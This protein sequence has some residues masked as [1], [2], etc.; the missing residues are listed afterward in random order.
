MSPVRPTSGVI[1][2]PEKVRNPHWWA[3]A[4]PPS[5][6]ATKLV[7]TAV[8]HGGSSPPT[9][10]AIVT[11]AS[12]LETRCVYVPAGAEQPA[13]STAVTVYVV[14]AAGATVIVRVVAPVDQRYDEYPAPAS[15]VIGA[16]AQLGSLPA[17]LVTTGAAAAQMASVAVEMLAETAPETRR[18]KT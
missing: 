16:P 4:P 3:T 6:R 2:P 10:V 12:E 8:P 18:R 1:E 9:T 15:S 13:A 7:P 11:D 5:S 17:V 14:V